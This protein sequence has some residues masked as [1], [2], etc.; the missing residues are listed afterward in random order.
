VEDERSR[1]QY[2]HAGRAE[3]L[4]KGEMQ[5]NVGACNAASGALLPCDAGD[6]TA[7]RMKP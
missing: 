5:T 2:L 4:Q 7:M 6:V 3:L 1:M